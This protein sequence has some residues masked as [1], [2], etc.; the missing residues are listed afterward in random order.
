MV[1]REV[2]TELCHGHPFYYVRNSYS[3]YQKTKFN[4]VKSS[5]STCRR[6]FESKY[7][8]N[9]HPISCLKM[10]RQRANDTWI[11]LVS[12]IIIWLSELQWTLL[13]LIDTLAFQCL[14]Q[15]ISLICLQHYL[16]RII[17]NDLSR[18]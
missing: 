4:R 1:I 9:Y 11:N 5:E 16:M 10:L 14:H 13:W 2:S 7:R 3:E 6:E 15:V 18:S 8:K 12:S 17:F